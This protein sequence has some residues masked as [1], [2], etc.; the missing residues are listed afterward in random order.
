MIAD[1]RMD[2]VQFCRIEA[3]DDARG[4]FAKEQSFV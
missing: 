1:D 4:R 3:N 2:C